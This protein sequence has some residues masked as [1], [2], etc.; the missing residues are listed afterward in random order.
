M[1]F[2]WGDPCM[3]RGTWAMTRTGTQHS[4]PR[5]PMWGVRGRGEVW[6]QGCQQPDINTQTQTLHHRSYAFKSPRA[7]GGRPRELGF[8]G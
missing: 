8:A 2:G 3:G 6:L 4:V 5:A 7:T 1:A